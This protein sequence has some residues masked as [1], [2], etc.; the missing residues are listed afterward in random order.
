MAQRAEADGEAGVGDTRTLPQALGGGGESHFAEMA[1]RR[2]ALEF[3]ENAREVEDTHADF[4]RHAGERQRFG[5][6]G[7]DERFRL[8]DS[9]RV[10]G[11]LMGAEERLRVGC[12]ASPTGAEGPVKLAGGDSARAGSAPAFSCSFSLR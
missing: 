8:I 4:L 10:P 9:P 7:A 3:V 1:V 6:V 5:V 2:L 11:Q 12:G